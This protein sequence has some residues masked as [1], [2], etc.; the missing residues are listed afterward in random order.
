LVALIAL[1]TSLVSF[2]AVGEVSAHEPVKIVASG[3]NNP[4]G[5][6]VGWTG[7][8]YV[9]E[10]GLGGDGP[11]IPGPEGEDVCFGATGSVTRIGRHGWKRVV[12]GLPSL[13]AA[14]GGGAAGPSDVIAGVPGHV[15]VLIGLGADPAEREGFPAGGELLGTLVHFD[16]WFRRSR[17]VADISAFEAAENP[18]GG[19]VDSNP[20]SVT[21]RWG[22]AFVADAG[23]NSL[24]EVRFDGQ[25][26]EVAVFPD[27]LVPAPPFLGLPPGAQIPM[28]AVPTSVIPAPDNK[29]LVGQLT[30]FPF[31][32]DGANV[33][34]VSRKTGDVEVFAF[35]FTNIIDLALDRHRNLYVLEIDGNGLLTPDFAGALWRVPQHGSPEQLDVGPLFAPAGLALHHDTL[36]LSN[37]GVCPGGGEVLA[38]DL[39][40]F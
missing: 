17:V 1:V 2:A 5:L 28:Q 18:D 11:C 31:P 35:G 6:D 10:A 14:G 20:V 19:E 29:L 21:A 39:D 36:Y 30:G 40:E 12:T 7:E 32:L 22:R 16:R 8:V 26:S 33:F 25:V 34:R 4:R 27:V 3:L 13:A 23:G 38:V 15:S 24:L 37:C 9:A